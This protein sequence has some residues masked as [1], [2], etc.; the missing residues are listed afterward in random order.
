VPDINLVPEDIGE[1]DL[2]EVL[3]LLVSIEV[4]VLEFLADVG[5]LAVDSLLLEFPDPTCSD[6]R[7]VLRRREHGCCDWEGR[8]GSPG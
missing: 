3:L 2:G 4:A 1:D 5:H 8:D 7:D 6:V